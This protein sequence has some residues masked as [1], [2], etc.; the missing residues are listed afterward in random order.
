MISGKK[1]LTQANRAALRSAVMRMA[2]L[3]ASVA[4]LALIAAAGP[5]WPDSIGQN[6]SNGGG[7][8]NYSTP[9][10]GGAAGNAGDGS[11]ATGSGGGGGAT[12]GS[13]NRGGSGGGSDG[14]GGGGAGYSLGAGGGGGG[15]GGA[16]LR[17]TTD[18][19][20]S[21]TIKGGNGGNGGSGA[22]NYSQSWNYAGGGGGGGGGSGIIVTT[23]SSLTNTGT[24]TGGNGGGGASVVGPGISNPFADPS[25]NG[26]GG[27]GGNGITA[28]ATNGLTINN[29]GTI[30]GGG[31]GTDFQNFQPYRPQAGGYG[32]IGQNLTIINSGTILGGARGG[33]GGLTGNLTSAIAI[34]GGTNSIQALAGSNIGKIELAAGTTTVSG[35]YSNVLQVNGGATLT[36]SDAAGDATGFTSLNNFGTVTIGA[37]SML[38]AGTIANAG[39]G[40]ITL[41]VGA[42]LFGTGNTLNNDSVI[43]VATD[44]VV[45]DNG[46]INNNATGTINF[47][48]PGGTAT[49]SPGVGY[50]VN[51][52][53]QINV[54][55]GATV[56]VQM[57]NLNNLGSGSVWLTGGDMFNVATFTN[58]DTATLTI[59]AG[60]KLSLGTLTFNGGTISGTGII[61]AA[62]NLN[63][64]GAG[65]IGATLAGSAGLVKTG[66][67]GMVI[68]TGN[69]T[70]TGGTTVSGGGGL[71]LGTSGTAGSIRGAV[72]VN[73]GTFNL[74]NADTT[75]ITGITNKATTNFYNNT[76]AGSATITNTG[77]LYFYDTSSAASARITN[78]FFVEFHDG[79]KA[80]ASNIT[81]NNTL[82]FYQ[83]SLAGN[84]AITNNNGGFLNFDNFSSADAAHITNGGTLAFYGNSSA[85]NAD[86]TNDQDLTFYDASQAGSAEIMNNGSLTFRSTATAGSAKITNNSNV[87]FL[88]NSNAGNAEINNVAGTVDFS[89][90]TGANGDKKLGAGS[91]AGGG[92]YLLG[93]NELT[94][95]S[96]DLSTEVS[97]TISGTGGSL[98]KIGNGTLKLSGT[99]TYT[100]LTA[101]SAG[102]L[103]GGKVNAFSSIGAFS[104]A[105]GATIDLGGFDQEISSLT[106]DGLVT[107]TGI[108]DAALTVGRNDSS[109]IFGGTIQDA[110]AGSLTMSKIGAGTLTLTGTS[111]HRGGTTVNAGTLQLGTIGV[112]GI[113]GKITGSVDVTASGTFDIVN[114]NSSSALSITSS[115]TTNFRNATSAGGSG[116]TIRIN[117]GTLNFHDTATGGSANINNSSGVLNFNDSSRAASAEIFNLQRINFNGD[118]S[119]DQAHISN[120]SAMNFDDR[121][122]AGSARIESDGI[123]VFAGDSTAG[124]AQ[125]SARGT[126]DFKGNS[127]A[128][129][130]A[131]TINSGGSVK[132]HDMSSG[133]NARIVIEDGG[134][135]EI[136]DLTSAGTTAGSIEG[137]GTYYLGSKK[138]TVGSNDQSTEVSGTIVDGSAG[139]GGSLAKTG[140]GTLTLSGD[141][142]Y[143][144]GT[145]LLGGV[146]QASR[147][148]NLGDASGALTFDGGALKLGAS[149]DLAATR[150]IM[151]NSG[152]GTIDTNGFATT[153]S[154][155]VGGTGGFTKTGSGTLTIA[156][157][158]AYTGAT[159]V[160]VGTLS[161]NGSI[162]SSSS[163]TVDYGATIGGSGTLGSTVVNGTLSA[164][165]S[166]GKLTVAGDLTLGST[167]TSLFELGA[168]GIV[169][170]PANDLVYVTG[171]LV[172]NGTLLTPGAVS[173]YYR[174]FD[175]DGTV[176]G[177]YVNVPINA[178]VQTAIPHQVNLFIQN[179][180]QIV[181]FWDGGDSI[182][183]GTVDGGAGIW[184]AAGTNWTGA[185]GSADFND[186]WRGSVAVFSGTGGV[187]KVSGP[188][189]FEGIQFASD[190]YKIEGDDLTLSGD[191]A[192]NT[193]ASFV[194]VNGGA[195]AEIASALTGAA[196]IGLDKFGSG[197]LILS[198]VNTYTGA[199]T[200]KSGTLAL[201]GNGSLAKSNVVAIENGTFDISG[202]TLP[203]SSITSLAGTSSGTVELGSKGLVITNGS[204]DFAGVIKGSGGVEI[205]GGTQTLSGVNTYTN[206]TQIDA[207]ATLALKGS[208]SIASSAYVGFVS[209]GVLDI[210]QTTAGAR[211]AGLFSATGDGIVAL[212]S[213]TLTI[214]NGS[215]FGGSIR[216]GGIGGGTGGNVV[217]AN[218]ATQMFSGVNM[219]T[220]STT[221]EQGGTLQLSGDGSL[222]ASSGVI[223]NG[224]FDISAQSTGSGPGIKALT[225]SGQVYLGDRNLGIVNADGTFSGV[226]SDCG[227]TGTDCFNTSTGGSLTLSGGTLT[228]T[229]VNTYTGGTTVGYFGAPGSTKLIVT[230]DHAVGSGRVLLNDAGLFQ[231]GADGLSFANRFE[232]SPSYGTVD[233]NGHTMTIAGVIADATDP[234]TLHKAGAGTLILTN[235]NTYGDGTVVEAGTL[236]LGNG[237][238]TGSILGDV[239]LGGTLAFNRSDTYTFSGVVSDK[240][241]SHGQLVQNGT[242]VVVLAGTNSY[243]GGTFFNKGTIAASSDGNL[244][245]A[246][247]ALTFDGG[248][249]RY[250][251]VFDVAASRAVTL[252][253]G[254]GTFDSNGFA[255]GVAAD[256]TGAGGLT[257]AGAGTL[258]LSGHNDYSGT[259]TVSQGMLK[260][261]V[262]NSFSARSAV[263][264]AGGAKLDLGSLDQVIGTLSGAGDVAMGSGNLTVD[265][266][267]NSTFSGALSGGGTFTKSGTGKLML[268]GT[269]TYTGQTFVKQGTLSVNGSIASSSG[270]TVETGGTLGGTGTLASVTV[271]NGGTLAPGNSIGTVNIAGNLVMGAGSTYAIE[272]DPASADRTNVTGTANLSGGTV[273]T[274]YAAATYIQKTYTI[275]NAQGGLGGTTFAGLTGTAPT[276]FTHKLAYDGNNAYLALDLDMREPGNPGGRPVFDPLNRNQR[277]VANAIVGYFD[278]KGGIQA[279]FGALDS[280]GLSLVSGEPTAGAI[281]AGIQG[282]DQFLGLLSGEALADRGGQGT[283]SSSTVAAFADE[284][285]AGDGDKALAALGAK[286][287]R[288]AG[289]VARVFDSRWRS[290]GA[291][292]GGTSEIGG[293][294]AAGSH[295]TDLKTFGLA[296]GIAR[297]WDDATLGIALGGGSSD[298]HLADKL[299]SGS[300]RFFN[301]GAFGRQEV[302]NAYVAAAAAYSFYDV[303]TSRTVLGT[304]LSGDFN[305]HAFSGRIEAGYD[306][307]TSLATLTP[308]AAFQAIAYRMPGYSET[309]AGSFGLTY[310]GNTTT[311]TRTELGARLDHGIGLDNDATLTLSGRAALAINGG[312]A[313]GFVA[314]FQALPGTS[315]SIE[316][317]NPDRYSALIDAGVQ[318][319]TANGFFAAATLQGE[320]SRNVH[321]IAGTVKIGMKW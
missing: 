206:A 16:G 36:V 304:V 6:G 321:N 155:S 209:N 27:L 142:T 153:V 130:A 167:S 311:V 150:Q 314:G 221:I 306:I 274:S 212:G 245:D 76:T 91:I 18:I 44:G 53:G 120:M 47:N 5:A 316:G 305:A 58:S 234:G 293:D 231:A 259:T 188:V 158:S 68:L 227:A 250:D 190:G 109:T 144:G 248:A 170:G 171:N 2:L 52:R 11:G 217:I 114:I 3:T 318:Y 62:N 238:T 283:S 189:G 237:G 87:A 276:G 145:S 192:N 211:I 67:S 15:A 32:I 303:E 239:E 128:E 88:F 22:A 127:N 228:L 247:G 175:V 122:T 289:P 96:N 73:S 277:S 164:G 50:S 213:K 39:A 266:T 126:V 307:E 287:D 78:N 101:V 19:V 269:S 154:Q 268:S 253:A 236:Q 256:I 17:L 34:T 196:G 296:G 71:Q 147:N 85:G 107:N 309:G 199:T 43:N 103:Q 313:I 80:G 69:N 203:F 214:T 89:G 235:D 64:L 1:N 273:A 79:S 251:A 162:A 60:R 197:T 233:T 40:G 242:G 200:I 94:V 100:G 297:K 317:A 151:L 55:G 202:T 258:T 319:A 29:S 262:A 10:G 300:A 82:L 169:G 222:F 140:A 205:A 191:S 63:L 70:Y 241:G 308:Y 84:A 291:T 9:G 139:T 226:I 143:T 195:T 75:A 113:A 285:T 123:T 26:A 232:V 223:A 282:T 246:A 181:Q 72:T 265:E 134:S 201:S 12:G 264:V 320:V 290:W 14:G 4:P 20:N 56:D 288:L 132:F 280:A 229:G 111:S 180:L 35:I 315:F 271:M 218:G 207:G 286:S 28:T 59:D 61:E 260:A 121:S 31:G 135:F 184:S 240:A 254:G 177:N 104:V 23:G 98:V 38:S 90:S 136:G 30:Q 110:G 86:I 49:L 194:T 131:V 37:G 125:I 116:D 208:G 124:T 216:E 183:N 118:S 165:N 295:D 275:L 133:G 163:V 48:G 284:K 176:S 115:G 255:A 279:E 25:G 106:G 108:S 81:N 302:G 193:S 46:D 93:D 298:F 179:G 220:G 141:N 160:A 187:V 156:G 51:N 219:F 166:P 129:S 112:G 66:P 119:A 117:A 137:A 41:G 24:V 186:Q 92:S 138:L 105:S 292:Y 168:P 54:A 252:Q 148:A 95:G 278:A 249:L 157:T 77:E 182:G 210:S 263:S 230:N 21:A 99:S 225:G 161:V 173:G 13:G 312:D 7:A 243:S 270:I 301:A 310:K 204:T 65:T 102:T 45:M 178:S 149:F 224:V 185:P 198:G 42:R 267:S 174:L 57:S 172:L 272:L 244:G 299:G 74:T 146:V 261:S 33:A 152:G 83:N 97:G 8:P 281:G 215:L 294:G 257:K 159:K